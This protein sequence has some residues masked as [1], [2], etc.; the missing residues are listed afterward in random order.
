MSFLDKIAATLAPAAS[1]EDMMKAR[2]QAE[3]IGASE[4]W[5][6]AIVDH[7]KQIESLIDEVINAPEASR[8]RE[9]LK[10]FMVVLTGHSVAEEVVI[11]PDIAEESSK[12]HAA[13]AYEEQS[14]TK[15]QVAM[16]EKIDPMSQEWRD[17]GEHIRSALQQHIYQEESSWYPTLAD[18]LSSTEKA[19][20]TERYN[21]EY[22]RYVGGASSRVGSSSGM[23]TTQ[24]FA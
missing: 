3:Q 18:K 19:R 22:D 13:M 23:T 16:L 5:L 4:P 2:Q 10:E 8:R 1:E 11:Y 15:V 6:R 20:M 7:H 21:E 12:A 17:K 14:M 24:T 9:A